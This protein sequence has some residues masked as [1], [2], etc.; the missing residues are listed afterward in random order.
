MFCKKATAFCFISLHGFWDILDTDFFECILRSD[1]IK[2]EAF[3]S[4]FWS[5]YN[6]ARMFPILHN[7]F[8]VGWTMFSDKWSKF[9]NFGILRLTTSFKKKSFSFIATYEGVI[10]FSKFYSFR[11]LNFIRQENKLLLLCAEVIHT[12]SFAY[13]ITNYLYHLFFFQKGFK[14]ALPLA[15]PLSRFHSQWN[16]CGLLANIFF[17]E[18][19]VFLALLYNF[20]RKHLNHF[21][22]G[23]LLICNFML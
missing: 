17:Y 9:S 11:R 23:T 15:R 10:F 6:S 7:S 13:K 19:H 2:R 22:K 18:T 14:K 16:V 21:R 4:K 5:Y 20:L 8:G 1:C 12:L 3:F